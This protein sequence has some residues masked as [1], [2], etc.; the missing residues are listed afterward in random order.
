MGVIRFYVEDVPFKIPHPNKTRQWLRRVIA[1]YGYSLHYLNYIF[2]SD[3]YVLG[4]NQQY[5]NHDYY[6]DIITFDQSSSPAHLAGDLFISIPRVTDNATALKVPF[7]EELNRV[8][9]HGVLH[10][11]GESD[12]SIKAK[13]A[14]R[15]AE[16]RF[17]AIR[18]F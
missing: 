3:E 1:E 5:L 11:L 10:L 7:L 18:E 15:K 14:M 9:V 2:A 8:M 17:L 4:V 16:D 13:A 6:T 12:K